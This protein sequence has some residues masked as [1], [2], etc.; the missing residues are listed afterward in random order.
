[1]LISL[2]KKI[3]DSLTSNS[4]L[5]KK[6]DDSLTSNS[7]LNN[8]LQKSTKN[9]DVIISDNSKLRTQINELLDV[10]PGDRVITEAGLVHTDSN[11]N[12]KKHDFKVTYECEILETTKNKFRLHAIDFHSTDSYTNNIRQSIIG[13]Y[14]DKWVD[15]KDC[16]IIIDERQRRDSKLEDLLS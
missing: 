7:T 1:M 2:S 6:I 9:L 13:Y 8:S 15:R 12:N 14:N 16:E 3:D 10:I 4:T 5:S 11:N